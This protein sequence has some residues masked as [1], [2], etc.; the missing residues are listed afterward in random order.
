MLSIDYSSAFNTIVPT[1][2]ITK[3][4]TLGLNTSLCYWIL[5]FL[6]GRYQ[7]VRVGNNTSATLIL[8]IGA[9]HI[10]LVMCNL[11]PSHSSLGLISEEDVNQFNYPVL[12]TAKLLALQTVAVPASSIRALRHSGLLVSFVPRLHQSGIGY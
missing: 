11:P 7:V 4:R 3:L 10:I 6:M 8:N 2:L 5:E 12:W 1:K 9:P